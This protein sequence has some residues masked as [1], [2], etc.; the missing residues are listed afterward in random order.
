MTMK[1]ASKS[2]AIKWLFNR[3]ISDERIEFVNGVAN[4][5]KD[6]GEKLLEVYPDLAKVKAKK[7]KEE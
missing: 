5:T 3:E 6:V 4:V 2:K 7:S 1:I